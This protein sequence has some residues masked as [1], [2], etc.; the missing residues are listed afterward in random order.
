MRILLTTCVVAALATALAVGVADSSSTSG[1]SIPPSWA[2]R[3]AFYLCDLTRGD[4][5]VQPCQEPQPGACFLPTSYEIRCG[6][7]VPPANLV[8]GYWTSYTRTSGCRLA[9]WLESSDGTRDK[10]SG[11]DHVYVIGCN[12]PGSRRVPLSTLR[13]LRAT[14]RNRARCSYDG[15]AVNCLFWRLLDSDSNTLPEVR[16]TRPRKCARSVGVNRVTVTR[17]FVH[18][19]GLVD[20]RVR[21]VKLQSLC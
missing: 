14:Y 19:V 5:D 2:N 3:A 11:D 7:R 12:P 17:G 10:Q 13:L 15:Y 6:E 18:R 20:F 9:E 8:Y 4:P 1:K 16:V 21:P